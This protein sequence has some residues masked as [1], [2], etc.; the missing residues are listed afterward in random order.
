M[1]ELTVLEMKSVAGGRIAEPVVRRP[2]VEA[3]KRLL[4]RIID[5]IRPGRSHQ[6]SPPSLTI[7]ERRTSG[8]S[9]LTFLLKPTPLAASAAWRSCSPSWMP[10]LLR[11]L[12]VQPHEMYSRKVELHGSQYSR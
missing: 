7:A 9:V 8:R 1:R 4:V 11:Q 6:R 3:I 12:P 5:S 10:K 2:V